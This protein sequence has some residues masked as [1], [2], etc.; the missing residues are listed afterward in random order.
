[1]PGVQALGLLLPSSG[2]VQV[3]INV[4]DTEQAPL[5][6]GG[7]ARAGGG[8]ERGVEVGASEL[9]GLLP[10]G[11]VADPALLGLDERPT[12]TCWNGGSRRG[13]SGSAFS[14]ATASR[15]LKLTANPDRLQATLRGSARQ[16]HTSAMEIEAD[17]ARRRLPELTDLLVD[18]VDGGG[19]TAS[20]GRSRRACVARTGRAGSETS[21]R[22]LDPGR[23][24]RRGRGADGHRRRSTWPGSRTDSIGPR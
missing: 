20:C 1:M 7:C 11:A 2:V 5:A 24:G 8:R 15:F 14:L 10:E 4:I 6:D 16:A 19:A 22:A 3:S 12:P 23:V 21:R 18:A 17:E 13:R 9:V